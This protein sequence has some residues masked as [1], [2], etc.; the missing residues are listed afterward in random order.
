M[1]K[2]DL[3][4]NNQQRL[5][6]HKKTTNQQTNQLYHSNDFKADLFDPDSNLY[7]HRDSDCT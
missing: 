4:T 1:Y 7:C 3:A 2:K 6:C 5:I